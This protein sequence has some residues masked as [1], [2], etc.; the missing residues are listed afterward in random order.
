LDVAIDW[1]ANGS[2]GVKIA[3][4]FVVRDGAR[5]RFDER[6][7]VKVAVELEGGCDDVSD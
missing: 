6:R 1:T 3:P 5:F 7:V 4:G 2:T